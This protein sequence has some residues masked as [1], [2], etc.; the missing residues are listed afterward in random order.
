[1]IA[2]RM[3]A[4]G[5][6]SR[7]VD[8]GI[9]AV[10]AVAPRVL[11]VSLPW[12]AYRILTLGVT[13]KTAFFVG[14]LWWLGVE[15]WYYADTLLQIDRNGD[16]T[17]GDGCRRSVSDDWICESCAGPSR[18]NRS[19]CNAKVRLP[20]DN[21]AINTTQAGLATSSRHKTLTISRARSREK[22]TGRMLCFPSFSFPSFGLSALSSH[23]RATWGSKLPTGG[24]GGF[25]CFLRFL[26]RSVYAKD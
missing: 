22:K 5:L 14:V 21:S 7:Y 16:R 20:C 10:L 13:P 12:S 24:L 25:A 8:Q 9:D 6:R 18:T 23:P 11:V 19:G 26:F 3:N 4:P 17:A 1:M 15:M 2:L